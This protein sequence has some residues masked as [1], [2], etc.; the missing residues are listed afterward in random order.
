[1]AHPDNAHLSPLD[2]SRELARL[3]ADVLVAYGRMAMTRT[4]EELEEVKDDKGEV[5]VRKS[6]RT[7]FEVEAAKEGMRYLGGKVDE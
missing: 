2:R 6:W 4:G 7:P 3:Y 1:M 5:T